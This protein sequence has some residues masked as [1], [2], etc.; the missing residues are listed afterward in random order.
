MVVV[1]GILGGFE[2][3]FDVGIEVAFEVG[4]EVVFDVGIEVRV[5]GVWGLRFDVSRLSRSG[6][7]SVR[8]V[9]DKGRGRRGGRRMS[10]ASTRPHAL[11]FPR[12]L[13][14]D[15]DITVR[16]L[17]SVPSKNAP[18]TLSLLAQAFGGFPSPSP[19]SNCFFS[20]LQIFA[21]SPGRIRR[22]FVYARENP[23]GHTS[24]SQHPPNTNHTD[25]PHF[26]AR[27]SAP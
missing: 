20:I 19:H 27:R 10:F 26:D 4:I 5:C 15:H 6:R 16:Y 9:S 21:R 1:G 8:V 11:S 18:W 17:L 3:V 23:R 22:A 12:K 14:S 13:L 24:S 2:V 7:Y 25:E